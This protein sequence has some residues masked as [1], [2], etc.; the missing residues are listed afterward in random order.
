MD[1]LLV[2]DYH[3][4]AAACTAGIAGIVIP[5]A[6]ATATAGSWSASRSSVCLATSLATAAK[7]SSTASRIQGR[8]TAA[9]AAG[10]VGCN[11]GDVAKISDAAT[12]GHVGVGNRRIMTRA[13]GTAAAAGSRRIEGRGRVFVR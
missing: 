2:A 12:T 4:A 1:N 5:T 11:T 3:D 13:T 6:A 8:H 10:V 7:T 9:T